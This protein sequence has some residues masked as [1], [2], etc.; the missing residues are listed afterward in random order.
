[1]RFQKMSHT[2]SPPSQSSW[3]YGDSTSLASISLFGGNKVVNKIICYPNFCLQLFVDLHGM[4]RTLAF[5]TLAILSAASVFGRTIPSL[6]ADH[7]GTFNVFVP[8]CFMTGILI[9]AMFG[10]ANNDG[11]IGFSIL[12]GFASGACKCS[13]LNDHPNMR[14]KTHIS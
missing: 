6:L 5:Y 9:W 8:I 10:I 2:R 4:S 3:F 13:S 12:Y 1:M 11:V 14:A 7:F